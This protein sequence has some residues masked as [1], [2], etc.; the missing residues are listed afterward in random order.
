MDTY[1]VGQLFALGQVKVG[2]KSQILQ[3]RGWRCPAIVLGQLGVEKGHPPEGLWSGRI[4][5]GGQG[6]SQYTALLHGPPLDLD[7]TRSQ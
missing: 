3:A 4:A 5:Q 6:S 1:Q 2:S 7:P